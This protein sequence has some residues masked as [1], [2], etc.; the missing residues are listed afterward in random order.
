MC[1]CKERLLKQQSMLTRTTI[2]AKERH[3][4]SREI[5]PHEAR[6]NAI[7]QKIRSNFQVCFAVPQQRF[8]HASIIMPF[9][10]QHMLLQ[11]AAMQGTPDLSDTLVGF[12]PQ[13]P[14][15]HLI[16]LPCRRPALCG[17]LWHRGP[18]RGV[19]GGGGACEPGGVPGPQVFSL[20]QWFC[21]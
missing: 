19:P 4:N 6:V 8:R 14:L 11:A 12:A 20:L 7:E 16:P 2:L 13:A 3:A 10:G 18:P 1:S 5:M 9:I 17:V 21:A 15:P